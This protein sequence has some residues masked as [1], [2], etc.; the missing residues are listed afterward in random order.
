MIVNLDRF[1]HTSQGILGRLRVGDE[2]ECYTI[3]RP[4]R[5][6]IVNISAIPPGEYLLAADHYHGGGYDT[7]ALRDV[8]GRSLIKFHRGNVATDLRGCIALGEQI[9]VLKSAPA[10][11][12]FMEA[13]GGKKNA[14]IIITD[15]HGGL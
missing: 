11:Q 9:G 8:P 12:G 7:F 3:E 2:F 14:R 15:C 4:W 13:M 10:F 1:I 6:N 5:G